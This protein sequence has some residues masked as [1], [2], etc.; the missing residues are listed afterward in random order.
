MKPFPGGEGKW[1]VSVNGGVAPRWG[2][3]VNDSSSS[4]LA[5]RSQVMEA[6]VSIAG[7]FAVGTPSPSQTSLKVGSVAPGWDVDADGTRFLLARQTPNAPRQSAPMT[8]IQNWFADFR[9][10]CPR[11]YL[12]P[13]NA[14]DLL[15]GRQRRRKNSICANRR[16][17]GSGMRSR[18]RAPL[19]PSPA[20]L[21]DR[22]KVFGRRPALARCGVG[23]IVAP[24]T[25][26]AR[27]RRNP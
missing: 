4:S 25:R 15:G 19:T 12:F 9:N 5:F 8:I 7:A 26:D 21:E 18:R 11:A 17:A 24:R 1:Q 27:A 14:A 6:E 16:S 3:R 2:R 13:R 10:R 23:A 20:A 22:P